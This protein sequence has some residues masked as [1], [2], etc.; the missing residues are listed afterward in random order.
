MISKS[1]YHTADVECCFFSQFHCSTFCSVWEWPT[2]D[3]ACCH[4]LLFISV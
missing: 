4:Y 2:T 3:P 1:V